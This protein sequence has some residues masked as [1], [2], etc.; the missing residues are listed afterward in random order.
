MPSMQVGRTENLF[1]PKKTSHHQR[2][3]LLRKLPGARTGKLSKSIVYLV[4][5][6]SKPLIGFSGSQISFRIE[7]CVETSVGQS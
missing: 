2:L 6:G 1:C 5:N 3:D 7:Y 4:R